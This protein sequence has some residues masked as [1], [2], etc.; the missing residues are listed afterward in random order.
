VRIRTS[1]LLIHSQATSGA[2]KA[3]PPCPL[4]YEKLGI[5][6]PRRKGCSCLVEADAP[7]CAIFINYQSVPRSPSESPS[8]LGTD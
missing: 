4:P 6:A 5:I 8:M 3:S 1:N 2:P 7:P